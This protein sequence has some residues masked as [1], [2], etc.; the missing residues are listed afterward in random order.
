MLVGQ[1]TPFPVV[2]HAI[3]SVNWIV[4][5]TSL[6]VF[7]GQVVAFRKASEQQK[8]PLAKAMGNS[9]GRIWIK[10]ISKNHNGASKVSTDGYA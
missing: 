10:P 1:A 8:V 9:P 7:S 4:L 5:V 6:P 3:G 2:Q